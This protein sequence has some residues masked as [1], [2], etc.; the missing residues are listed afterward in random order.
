MLPIINMHRIKYQNANNIRADYRRLLL[1]NDAPYCPTTPTPDSGRL[2]PTVGEAAIRRRS[3]DKISPFG[4][5]PLA[6]GKT[7]HTEPPI[8]PTIAQTFPTFYWG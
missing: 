8:S 2:L 1:S 6:T 3:T 7:G 4:R 5:Q